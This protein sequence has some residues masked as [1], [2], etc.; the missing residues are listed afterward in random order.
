M[1]CAV[2]FLLVTIALATPA[3]AYE[4][5]GLAWP[6]GSAHYRIAPNFP[7]PS[8]AGSPE[9]QL[10]ILR[11]AADAWSF[12]SRAPFAFDYRGLAS[13]VGN[14]SDGENAVGYSSDDGGDALAVTLIRGVQNRATSFDIVFFGRSN[15][16]T[17][18][19][20][21][22]RDP[23][24]LLGEVDIAGVAVHEYGHALGLD[25]S[26]TQDATMFPRVS[27]TGVELRT[28]HSDD[29][30]GVESIYGQVGP[31]DV[32][33]T[34]TSVEP[35]FGPGAGG[36]VVILEGTNF[37]WTGNTVLFAGDARISSSS[38]EVETCGRIRIAAMPPGSGS[39]AIEL[40]NELGTVV[41]ASGYRYG[42][43]PP[44]ITGI[45]PNVVP[46]VGGVDV[47][48]HGTGF[49]ADGDWSIGGLPLENVQR[50]DAQRVI[51]RAPA[52]TTPGPV[53]VRL[54]QESGEAVLAQGLEYTAKLLRLGSTTS[55]PGDE[56]ALVDMLVSTDEPLR[57]ISFAFRYPADS[58]AVT[59]IVVDGT[60]SETAEFVA[61]NIDNENGITTVG[62]V[63]SFT[64]ESPH[65][66]AGDDLL[67][68]RIETIV[69]STVTPGSELELTIEERG[70]DPP[71][72]LLMTP[73]DSTD[74]VRPFASGG[75]I[76]VFAHA[77]F[78]RGDID[79]DG[80]LSLTDTIQLLGALF[81]G[82]GP[83]F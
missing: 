23:D 52:Q 24:P 28:L 20:T 51:G 82:E 54:S 70:G 7:S 74:P 3:S 75:S 2:A 81:H 18:L 50:L 46:L 64:A 55:T 8:R 83:L 39:V 29:R 11:C 61:P 44:T 67:V 15:G 40:R 42:D 27:R 72:E 19:W 38:F 17:N 48:I 60:L 63:A 13:N 6:N 33:P 53:D 78:I 5:L 1:S 12:Q 35:S 34:I 14:S 26:Q 49:N 9:E 45:D 37:T 68:G 16:R 32:A 36:N 43:A 47:T 57:G 62:I 21:G 30:A 4:P 25:H 69:K 31:L 22:T 58:L 77:Q 10:E 59:G 76:Q 66:P 71:I 79:R 41:L 73:L 56:S 80:S 65:F